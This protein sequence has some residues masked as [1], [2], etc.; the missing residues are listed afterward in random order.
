M[1]KYEKPVEY[2]S[3][4]AAIFVPFFLLFQIFIVV[5][6]KKCTFKDMAI[7]V[8]SIASIIL[9]YSNFDSGERQPIML[10]SGLVLLLAAI[11]LGLI[12]LVKLII[13]Q[14][15]KARS[16]IVGII[17][18]VAVFFG[19]KLNNYFTGKKIL[20]KFTSIDAE[21]LKIKPKKRDIGFKVVDHF[22]NCSFS[23]IKFKIPKTD[24]VKTFKIREICR[25]FKFKDGSSLKIIRDTLRFSILKN[26]RSKKGSNDNIIKRY[27]EEE[28]INSEFDLLLFT[29]NKTPADISFFNLSKENTIIQY[30]F[31]KLKELSARSG[32]EDGFYYFNLTNLKGFQFGG[33]KAHETADI[34]IFTNKGEEYTLLFRGFNQ[35]QI[36]YLI[37]SVDSSL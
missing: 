32:A 14:S 1:E 33:T 36:D 6:G 34:Q 27:L 24:T 37:G 30:T 13:G 15:M 26:L 12:K 9:A 10:F 22:I 28:K 4:L 3:A 11:L 17:V 16:I 23:P 5:K 2:L 35:E 21:Y 19:I 29:Y 7:I 31:L 25:S 18:I 8:A 20:G